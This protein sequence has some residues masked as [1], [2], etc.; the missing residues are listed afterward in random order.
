MKSDTERT[1]VRIPW[2]AAWSG[3]VPSKE[4]SAVQV[5]R[6]PQTGELWVFQGGPDSPQEREANGILWAREGL[7]RTGEPLDFDSIYRQRA[8]MRR[9]MCRICGRVISQPVI[10]WLLAE[11]QL[12]FDNNGDAL[13][14][15]PPTCDDCMDIA[16]DL[17][18][19]LKDACMTVKVLSYEL[20]GVWGDAALEAP[21]DAT[22]RRIAR[23]VRIK[24]ASPPSNLDLT[25][26]LAKREVVRFEKFRIAGE[27]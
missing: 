5:S 9:K 10:H 23:G 12:E 14:V 2:V 20:W 6:N 19:Q 16:S 13:T 27:G 26:V 15:T 25:A 1:D 8:A 17:Y 21:G 18:P 4:E 7:A 3:A 11:G 22:S 24:R